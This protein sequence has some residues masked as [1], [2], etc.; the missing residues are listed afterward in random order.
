MKGFNHN[1]PQYALTTYHYNY[2][3][4]NK[5]NKM[6]IIIIDKG[7]LNETHK[8]YYIHRNVNKTNK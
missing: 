4:N 5:I 1:T 2:I 8:I 3:I 7:R 6:D